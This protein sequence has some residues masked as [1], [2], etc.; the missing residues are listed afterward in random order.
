MVGDHCMRFCFINLRVQLFGMAFN[1]F[2]KKEQHLP[3][4][5][6]ID[7][8]YISTAAKMNACVVLA[9]TDP[10][11]VFIAWFS[12]TALKFKEFF[13]QHEISESRVME[14]CSVHTTLGQHQI[15]VFA[16]HYPLHIKE[17]EL[18][19]NW[20]QQ[21]IIVF[22]AMDE[23]LF[24]FFGSEKLIPL[25]K[26][27]GMKEAEPIEHAMVS[28]SIIKSQE[29]IASGITIEQTAGSQAEWME[30]NIR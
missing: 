8:T 2:G 5:I 19:N 16:E 24:K 15:P 10:D 26:M 22:S 23:P 20:P 1:L 11:I 18:M 9:K 12:E 17:I 3:G 28:K 25:M 14:A 4:S 7:K 30:K 6:F 21:Q 27:M 29:K 13:R